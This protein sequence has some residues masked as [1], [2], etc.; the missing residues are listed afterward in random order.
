RGG[1]AGRGRERDGVIAGSVRIHDQGVAV[2]QRLGG[3]VVGAHD[4]GRIIGLE[5][6][7]GGRDVP[8]RVER[9]TIPLPR[10]AT[11]RFELRNIEN[12]AG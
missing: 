3:A 4:G 6:D 7:S 2:G 11:A 8:D 5:G 1:R 12:G 9:K 10:Q